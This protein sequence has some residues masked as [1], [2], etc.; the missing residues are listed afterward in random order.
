MAAKDQIQCSCP[1]KI[2]S[3]KEHSV[4]KF[5]LKK[6]E[7][8]SGPS[9]PYLFS[10]DSLKRCHSIYPVVWFVKRWKSLGMPH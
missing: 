8:A 9:I 3:M 10:T 7:E 4:R 2:Y 6:K 5:D 1:E